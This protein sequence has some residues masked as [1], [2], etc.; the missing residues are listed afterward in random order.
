MIHGYKIAHFWEK[1]ARPWQEPKPVTHLSLQRH[2]SRTAGKGRKGGEKKWNIKVCKREKSHSKSKTFFSDLWL[3]QIWTSTHSFWCFATPL[4]LKSRRF[5]T[6][7][8]K[9]VL[10]FL[11]SSIMLLLWFAFFILNLLFEQNYLHLF[12]NYIPHGPVV[13]CGV[14]CGVRHLAS[15]MEISQKKQ[16]HPLVPLAYVG[17]LSILRHR[18]LHMA[19]HQV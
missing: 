16:K 2:C 4:S 1:V 13:W 19:T 6:S 18:W 15:P 7:A 17:N 10:K 9:A 3:F 12:T 5:P 8:L 14:R 11:S